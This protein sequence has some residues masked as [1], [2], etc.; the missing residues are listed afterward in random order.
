MRQRGGLD[1][2]RYNVQ[3]Q[4]F[5]YQL[6]M[7]MPL[8]S[9]QDMPKKPVLFHT[10]TTYASRS[11]RFLVLSRFLGRCLSSGLHHEVLMFPCIGST[12]SLLCPLKSVIQNEIAF[13]KLQRNGLQVSA[14]LR[15]TC[16]GSIYSHPCTSWIRTLKPNAH[17]G[18]SSAR[19]SFPSAFCSLPLT[20]A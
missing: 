13:K 15:K 14:W 20:W 9:S 16:A 18:A 6:P 7:P 5:C 10:T 12:H 2:T 8:F 1:D 19:P 4:F 17:L 11:P 3:I